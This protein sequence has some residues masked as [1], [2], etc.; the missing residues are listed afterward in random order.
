MCFHQR[1]KVNRIFVSTIKKSNINLFSAMYAHQCNSLSNNILNA[2]LPKNVFLM[3]EYTVTNETQEIT[4]LMNLI[5]QEN[6]TKIYTGN[7]SLV[8]FGQCAP[9]FAANSA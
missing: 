6:Y 9:S 7:R 1:R 3:L 2:A 4:I 5:R 8:F